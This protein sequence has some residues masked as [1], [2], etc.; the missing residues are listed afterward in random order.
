MNNY[1]MFGYGQT[2]QPQFQ[3]YAPPRIHGRV[4]S[5]ANE[6]GVGDVP[7]DG[8]TGW[9]PAYDGSCVWGKRWNPNGSIETICYRPEPVEVPN[10]AD[11][12]IAALTE[13]VEALEA[14]LAKKPKRKEA[15]VD[16]P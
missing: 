5:S 9:F 12:G 10:L 4:V 8:T 7:T 15:A 11:D 16:E 14:A 3:P 6:I 1:Q 13:R 2:Y